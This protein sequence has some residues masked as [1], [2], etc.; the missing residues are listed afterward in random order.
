MKGAAESRAAFE[1]NVAPRL[2][3]PAPLF[4][5]R[6]PSNPRFAFGTVGGRY[7]VLCFF[8]SARDPRGRRHLDTVLSFADAY[9]DERIAM[10]GVSCD[11]RDQDDP[12][13]AQRI[14][15]IRYFWDFDSEVSRLYGA[16]EDEVP[17][18]RVQVQ[19]QTVIVDP[20]MRILARLPFDDAG[21]HRDMLGRLLAALPDPELHAGVPL[22]APVLVVPR[23]F[24][25][26][27]CRRLIEHYDEAG[28]E[29]SGFMR[30]V[31]G[32]TIGM[33]DHGM[34]RRRDATI[35]DQSLIEATRSRIRRRLGPQIAR[36][37][38]FDATRIERFI[39]ACYDASTGGFFRPHRDNGT[40]GTAHRRFAVTINLNAEDYE[41]GDLRFP[42]YGRRTYRAP[43]GGA[44]VFSCSLLHEATPITKGRR[45]CFLPFLYGEEDARLRRENLRF[46]GAA[47]S[48]TL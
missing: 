36:A 37:F 12:D 8:G 34:K 13:L 31:E 25:P 9:D 5:A 23:I 30:E 42:E 39:V 33:I 43:T 48:S 11:P 21:R 41:G 6:T 16:I 40:K 2:H 44:V 28:S 29:D 18:S 35:R 7:I 47:P 15:G 4:F 14:P 22:H 46:V 20:S 24:E 17:A 3:E 45:F 10:F 27:L 19:P 26:E 1:A 38:Q 32:R